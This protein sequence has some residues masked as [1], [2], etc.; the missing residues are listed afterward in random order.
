M[1]TENFVFLRAFVPYQIIE[2]FVNLRASVSL[3]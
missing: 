1:N 3:W 2:T